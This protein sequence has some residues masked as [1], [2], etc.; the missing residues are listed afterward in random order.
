MCILFYSYKEQSDDQTDSDD[1]IEYADT[2]PAQDVKPDAETIEKV[3]QDRL[4][5]KGGE[6]M[7]RYRKKTTKKNKQTRESVCVID[8]KLYIPH[9]EKKS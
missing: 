2:A 1:L 9:T 5:K 3:L 4:G 6:E 8:L 7:S